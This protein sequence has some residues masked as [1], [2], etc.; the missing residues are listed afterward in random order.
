MIYDILIFFIFTIILLGGI[1]AFF[2]LLKNSLQVDD[3]HLIDA[4]PPNAEKGD[5]SN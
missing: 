4:K 5:H 2:M 3:E 1:G